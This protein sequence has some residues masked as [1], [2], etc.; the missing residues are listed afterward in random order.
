MTRPPSLSPSLSTPARPSADQVTFVY[1]DLVWFRPIQTGAGPSRLVPGLF[2]RYG[3]VRVVIALL[4]SRD[5]LGRV[6]RVY[7]APV[8]VYRRFDADAAVGEEIRL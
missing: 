4:G 6:R 1:G 3:A 2:E 5:A 8:N 7:V